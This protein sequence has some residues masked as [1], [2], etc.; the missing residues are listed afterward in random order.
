MKKQYDLEV[1]AAYIGLQ[2]NVFRRLG[3]SDRHD[4]AQKSSD[5]LHLHMMDFCSNIPAKSVQHIQYLTILLPH[6][7]HSFIIDLIFLHSI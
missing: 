2:A 1:F 3:F 4:L 7:Y 6:A 5:K